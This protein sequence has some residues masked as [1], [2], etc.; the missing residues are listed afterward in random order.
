LS[1]KEIEKLGYVM[2][3]VDH[4]KAR[5]RAIARYKK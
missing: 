1:K 3:I 5:K 4:A 2:P